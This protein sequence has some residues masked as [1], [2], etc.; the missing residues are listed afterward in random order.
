MLVSCVLSCSLHRKPKLVKKVFLWFREVN[1]FGGVV[2][3]ESETFRYLF[4]SLS[5]LEPPLPTPPPHRPHLL[6]TE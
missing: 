2:T 6:M 1:I 5:S 3:R 4:L